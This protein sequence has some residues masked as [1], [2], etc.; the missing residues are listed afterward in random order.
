[1]SKSSSRRNVTRII[2]GGVVV[3]IVA[4]LLNAVLSISSF[5]K[6]YR[7]S[8]ISKYRILAREFKT[9][10]ERDVNFGRPVYLLG[11][12]DK[13]FESVLVQDDN[14]EALYVTFPDRKIL[15]S[16]DENA[17]GM[18][19]GSDEFPPF[20]AG[21]TAADLTRSEVTEYKRS[22]FV[23]A[24][25]YYDDSE[26]VGAIYLEF[27]REIITE[28]IYEVIGQN[29]RYFVPILAAAILTIVVLLFW[30]NSA[31]KARRKAGATTTRYTIAIVAVLL[32]GQLIYAFFNNQYFEKTYVSIFEN[33]VDSIS[34]IMKSDFD[35][36]LGYDLPLERMKKA[37]ELMD[38]SR[39]N[40]KE[41]NR[42]LITDPDGR[43][44]YAASDDV[45]AGALN[46]P[47]AIESMDPISTE[48]TPVRR[49][50]PLLANGVTT[51]YLIVFVNEKLIAKQLR[52]LLL[53]VLTVIIVAVIFSL[54][55]V[56]LLTI[57]VKEERADGI[58]EATELRIVRLTSFIFFF[59]ALIPLSFLPAFIEQTFLQNPV[60]MFGFSAKTIISL[61]IASYM[62]GITIFIPIV[63]FLSDRLT[64]R[65]IFFISGG[66]FIIGTLSTAFAGNIIGLMAA[67]FVAGLGYGGVIINSTNLVISATNENNRSMGFGLWSAGFAA[68]TICAIS[69][70][71][72]VVNRLG[73]AVGIFVATGFAALL[74][75]FIAVYIKP[76]V[77]GSTGKAQ[78]K[79]R[80]GF[81]EFVALF[82]NR[83]L[84]V[85]L[86]FSSVPFSMAYIGLFQ[87]VFPLYMGSKS[88]SPANIGRILTVY[89]LIS[90]ATPLISKIA[91]RIK[92]EKAIIIIG[93]SITGVSL[94]AFYLL[95]R[96]SLT[97]NPILTLIPVILGMGLG[98][99]M[100]DAVEES[101][102]TSSAEAREM[103]EAKL[104][105]LYTTYDKVISIIV[106][107]LAGTLI[108]ALGYSASIGVIGAFTTFGVIVFAIFSQNL[109]RMK[110]A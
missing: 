5:E 94:L 103:G 20:A 33:N 92:N 59:A 66:L 18:R 93:N 101:F 77:G 41:T 97:I 78:A 26:L 109:R 110:T 22:F 45:V 71:G 61:P 80:V 74:L 98:G 25:V 63:G 49:V 35:K 36:I 8:L 73:F 83:S 55:L 84:V 107:V 9:Q 32:L 67:R 105:S 58:K 19:L 90:L 95:D 2:I 79:E 38:Q 48:Q 54:E 86:V 30:V 87:Y 10:V 82:K 76:S 53:D 3:L 21:P 89:G 4:Q 88:I 13:I 47:E 68:A 65:R 14:I 91:D 81:R 56:R 16:T 64:V 100:I 44:L 50:S 34:R 75:A 1:M 69:I 29:V 24:P 106:P 40:S 15:Y 96:S 72:V 108:T 51:G 42:I 27:K 99:M 43:I 46:N 7:E 85:N 12:I 23:S 104:L 28:G 11:G 70:G 39:V 37:E 6:T 31:G 17:P 52:D 102:I 62:L 60:S 57:F